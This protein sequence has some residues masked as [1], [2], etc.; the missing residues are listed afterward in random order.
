MLNLL[1]NSLFLVK[2]M[3]GPTNFPV[4][5]FGE[6]LAVGN[7]PSNALGEVWLLGISLDMHLGIIIE[8]RR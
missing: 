1:N 5:A 4:N 7:F 3:T 2:Q 6:V 8:L